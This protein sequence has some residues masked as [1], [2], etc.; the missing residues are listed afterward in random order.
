[1][2]T[3]NERFSLRWEIIV[4]VRYATSLVTIH[5]YITDKLLNPKKNWKMVH[6]TQMKQTTAHNSVT[7]AMQNE[8]MKSS[9]DKNRR[10][11]AAT[12][13]KISTTNN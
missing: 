5:Y 1:M 9:T 12:C 6:I 10:T 8:L 7:I 13:N 3:A 2:Q 11:N 4:L